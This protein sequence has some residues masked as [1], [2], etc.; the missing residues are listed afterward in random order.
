M[1]PLYVLIPSPLVGP[2]TWQGVGTELQRIGEAVCIP[3]LTD[4]AMSDQPF[5]QPH[6]RAVLSSTG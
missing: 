4:Q 2:L 3:V 6:A 1:N 5:W